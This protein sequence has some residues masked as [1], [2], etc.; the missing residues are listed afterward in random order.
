MREAIEGSK[1]LPWA[2][3]YTV[4]DDRP[5]STATT[6][7]R[8]RA[9]I[10]IEIERTMPGRHPRFQFEAK[11]LYRSDSVAE[12]VGNE[13]LGAFLDN[14]YSSSSSAAGMLGYVQNSAEKTWAGKIEAKLDVDRAQHEIAIGAASVWELVS[15][16]GGAAGALSYHSTHARSPMSID[17]FH[18]FL[19]CF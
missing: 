12:Y 1:R 13:G 4:H 19:R 5:I 18:T 15:L 11:R 2:S 9:R 6:E 8:D 10:D 14:T 3:R 7:G 16:F 17:V